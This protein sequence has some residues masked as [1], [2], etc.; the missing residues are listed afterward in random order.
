MV[1]SVPDLTGRNI[2]RSFNIGIPYTKA[3]NNTQVKMKDLVDVYWSNNEIF[4]QD[5]KRISSNNKTF[6]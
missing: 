3:E 6:K 2:S 4:D 1:H 5:A